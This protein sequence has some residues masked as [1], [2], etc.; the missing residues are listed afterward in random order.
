VPFEDAPMV[1]RTSNVSLVVR[2]LTAAADR[3]EL[4]GHAE[5]VDSGEVVLLRN[6]DD[7]AALVRRI[8]REG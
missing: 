4:I 5:V 8:G 3:G 7:L 6:A 1:I 2:L